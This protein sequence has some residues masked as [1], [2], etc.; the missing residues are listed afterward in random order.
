MK[1]WGTREE[2]IKFWKW[3]ETI[4]DISQS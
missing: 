1:F 2:L 4:S 3:S